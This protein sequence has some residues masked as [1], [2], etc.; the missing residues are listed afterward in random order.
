[1][2]FQGSY[3]NLK[4]CKNYLTL[5]PFIFWWNFQIN[6]F[7]PVFTNSTVTPVEKHI[8]FQVILVTRVFWDTSKVESFWRINSTFQLRTLMMGEIGSRGSSHMKKFFPN[9]SHKVRNPGRYVELFLKS[10]FKCP[11]SEPWL[12]SIFGELLFCAKN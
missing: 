1:M 5:D 9:V 3:C 2:F 11:I 10:T 12:N 8:F 6:F 7:L 4:I